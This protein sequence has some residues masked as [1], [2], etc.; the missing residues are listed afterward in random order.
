MRVIKPAFLLLLAL[1]GGVA[2]STAAP[3]YQEEKRIYGKVTDES[4]EPLPNVSVIL[5]YAPF[6][7]IREQRWTEMSRTVTSETGEYKFS[8]RGTAEKE[9]P[10][11]GYRLT[12]KY[13]GLRQVSRTTH[14]GLNV[15]GPDG[16]PAV[17]QEVNVQLLSG[18][19]SGGKK[20]AKREKYLPP[21]PEYQG[22]HGDEAVDG[23]GSQPPRYKPAPTPK[24]R[25]TPQPTPTP[26]SS[27]ANVPANANTG[28]KA[29]A[30]PTSA[31][32]D[33][34]LQSLDVGNI[35]FNTPES[36]SLKD[37]K[38]VELLLSTSLSEEELKKAVAKQNVQ[39]EI[40]AESIQI[41]DQMEAN[42]S[43][44]GFQIT[45]VL[46]ARRPISRTGT[47]EWKWDVRALKEGKL[48]LHLTLNAL[49][50]IGGS[51]ELYPIKTFDKE[52]VV[53]VGV[54]DAVV[55]FA[56]DHWQWLWTTIF[57]PVGAWMWKRRRTSTEANA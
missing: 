41:S 35:A 39:G 32:I 57:L 2:L 1:F 23:P 12:F 16:V 21:P 15:S 45:D 17:E 27:N 4:G 56:K 13:P 34:I 48:R 46:P 37:P 18:S 24:P 47:T 43:G 11:G 50:T 14:L 40:Q 54:T 29:A 9:L 7:V 25:T 51:S 42:L 28:R 22:G 44:D 26:T 52:Y 38:K 36:M 49:V 6:G 19:I 5:E 53:T 20:S 33:R 3:A 10:S 55:G 8:G 31:E 30:E